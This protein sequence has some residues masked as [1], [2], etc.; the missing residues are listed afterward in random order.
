MNKGFEGSCEI[1]V[2]SQ[3]NFLGR[4]SNTF[5]RNINATSRR[6]YQ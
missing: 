1:I 4:A 5:N 2:R 6:A 3:T